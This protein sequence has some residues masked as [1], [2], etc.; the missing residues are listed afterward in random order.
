MDTTAA[1]LAWLAVAARSLTHGPTP[2]SFCLVM[3]TVTPRAVRRSRT[4]LAT[5][6]VKAC[7][8]SPALVDVPVVLQGFI[9]PRPSGTCALICAACEALP[10]LCPGS[11]TTTRPGGGLALAFAAG[12]VVVVTAGGAEDAGGG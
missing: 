4:R 1:G 9:R 12:V 3:I 2:V 7:S 5:S 6:Q 8:V 10:P 11:R